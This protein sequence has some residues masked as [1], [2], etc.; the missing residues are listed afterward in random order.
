MNVFHFHAEYL[1]EKG[2]FNTCLLPSNFTLDFF[3]I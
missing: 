2:Q 1:T 3:L